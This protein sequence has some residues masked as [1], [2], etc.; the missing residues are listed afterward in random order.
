MRPA[1]ALFLEISPYEADD[2]HMIGRDPRQVS[3][4]EIRLLELQ[5]SPAKAIRSKCIDCSGGNA[6][7]ARKCVA[8]NCALWPFRMGSNPFHA[9]SMSSK[10]ELANVVISR[11]TNGPAE[12]AISPSPASDEISVSV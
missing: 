3:L 10:R 8:V 1:R 4:G 7:E 5:E 11:E 2:G 9:S 12:A 6:A